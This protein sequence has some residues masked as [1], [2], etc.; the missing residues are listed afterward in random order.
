MT[1]KTT[2]VEPSKFAKPYISNAADTLQSTVANNAG[3]LQQISQGLSSQLPAL[4]E[5]AFGANPLNTAASG[6]ATDVLGGKYLGA[7]NPYLND[8]V[9]QSRQNTFNSISSAFG[10]SGLTGST[11]FAESLGRGLGQ[12]ESGLRYNDY[13]TERQRQ[14]A[15]SVNARSINAAQYDGVTPYL[16]T[17]QAAAQTPYY[18]AQTLASGTGGL[19]GQYN[20]QTQRGG[21]L[22]TLAGLAGQGLSAWA[23][24]GF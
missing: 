6:Y 8:I 24:G 14:D 15:A 1:K 12:A 16:Q 23:G 2:T 3:N 17:A 11:G 13:N 20:T 4:Q 22:G 9:D 5:K 19:L 21:L 18:G 7:T 10:R